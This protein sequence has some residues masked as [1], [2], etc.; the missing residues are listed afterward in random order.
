MK[1]KTEI[2]NT[3]RGE[4]EMRTELGNINGTGRLTVS[5]SCKDVKEAFFL[6]VTN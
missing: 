3:K 4:W 5:R 1:I 2:Y 6:E